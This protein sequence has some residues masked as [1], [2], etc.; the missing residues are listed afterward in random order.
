MSNIQATVKGYPSIAVVDKPSTAFKTDYR[1]DIDGLRGIA[2]IFV[3]LYHLF[4]EIFV[5]GFIGVDIF[6]VI[7]GFLISKIIFSQLTA[8]TFSFFDFY[9]RRIKRIFPALILI[10]ALCFF[11]GYFVLFPD[12]FTHLSKHV[13]SASLFLSNLTLYREVGYFDLTSESKP[14]LHLWS[15]AVEEQFY[16]IWP[17]F[18]WGLHKISSKRSLNKYGHIINFISITIVTIISFFLYIFLVTFKPNLAFY[19]T[20]ARL[21]EMSIGSLGAY[22]LANKKQTLPKI[23]CDVI[24]ISS[25][26]CILF[27]FLFLRH[28]N[29]YFSFLI[30]FPVLGTLFLL[31]LP[32]SVC[33]GFVNN[34]ILSHPLLVFI[35]LISYP[36]Y[37]LHWPCISFIKIIS[38]KPLSLEGK[39]L[40]FGTVIGISY[41]IYKYVE[42]PIRRKSSLSTPIILSILFLIIG[43]CGHFSYQGLLKP[44]INYKLPSS[45]KITAA[46]NDWEYPTRNMHKLFYKGEEFYKIGVTNNVILFFGDS[47][48]EQYAPRVDKIITKSQSHKAA[49]FATMGG[50]CPLPNVGRSDKEIEFVNKVIDYANSSAAHTIVITGQWFGYLGGNAKNYLYLN[51]GNLSNYNYLNKAISD[52]QKFVSKL[53]T[54]G[55]KVYIVSSIPYGGHYSPKSF[56]KRDFIGNWHLNLQHA[57]RKEWEN[58]NLKANQ[59]LA[60]IARNTG[61]IIIN[62]ESSLCSDDICRTYQDDGSPIY[63]D[64]GHLRSSYVRQHLNYLDF[65]FYN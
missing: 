32:R 17:L 4:P 16:L 27:S 48:A 40:I 56:F 59:A 15:L 60:E 29:Q 1:A 57:S 64:E 9:V 47:N 24:H 53:I 49:V 6:F 55:K 58:N 61:A 18:L 45:V 43:T 12:E 28:S 44:F 33:S 51:E 38:N 52:F 14:L 26:I 10:C 41:A 54:K 63:K 20:G 22:C 13:K 36:V 65:L 62:P 21:W 30:L 5:G 50:L 46:F 35:G 42:M 25:I 31:M 34:K 11:Y 19:F 23:A 3:F 8:H 37:L 39:I 7:S 2:I